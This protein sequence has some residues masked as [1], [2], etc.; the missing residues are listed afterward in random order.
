MKDVPGPSKVIPGEIGLAKKRPST[1]L[2]MVVINPEPA[3]IKWQRGRQLV[4]VN[5]DAKTIWLMVEDQSYLIIAD[6]T[7]FV[8]I[9]TVNG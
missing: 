1:D 6:S 9:M 5:T 3:A 8:Y 2:L 7:Y 4:M